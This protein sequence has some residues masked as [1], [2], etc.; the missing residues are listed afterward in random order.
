LLPKYL[1]TD[2]DTGVVTV[3]EETLLQKNGG[4]SKS[5]WEAIKADD[6]GI[7]SK[8]LSHVISAVA[9]ELR[10]DK[11]FPDLWGCTVKAKKQI[12]DLESDINK[13]LNKYHYEI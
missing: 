3:D 5:D 11:W 7:F 6:F 9:L 4:I 12:L 10:N 2:K 13:I 1:H 8:S